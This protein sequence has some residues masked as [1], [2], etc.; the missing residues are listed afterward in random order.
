MLHLSL[1]V[2]TIIKQAAETYSSRS[3]WKFEMC[4]AGNYVIKR[5]KQRPRGV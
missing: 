2:V 5:V 4:M 1:T 3:S